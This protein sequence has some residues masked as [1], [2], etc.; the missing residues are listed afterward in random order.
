MCAQL[1]AD[2]PT[3]KILIY[4]DDPQ[5]ALVDLPGEFLGL[6][7]MV[8]RLHAHAPAFA[9]LE[10]TLVNRN[11]NAH[12]DRRIDVVLDEA[13]NAGQPFDEIWF[14]GIHQANLDKFSVGAFRGGQNSE[15]SATE[16]TA[17]ERWM[18]T[19]DGFQGGGVLITGDHAN[20]APPGL[21]PT[22]DSPCGD[23]SAASNSLGLGRAIGRCVPR[24][25]ALRIWEGPPTREP[26]DSFSTIAS[27]V[28]L[29]RFPQ[30]L[31]LRNV[32]VDGDPD[33]SGQPHPLFFYKPDEFIRVFPDHAH[34]GAVIIPQELNPAVWPSGSKGQTRPQIVA[35]GTDKRRDQ[36]LNIVATYNGDLAGVGRIVAD[37]TWHHYMNINLRGF[38]HPAP[39]GSASD[40]IGQFYGNLAVW[41]APRSKRIQ[42]ARAMSWELARYT[43][44]LE[45]H[46]NPESIGAAARWLMEQAASPCEVHELLQVLSPAESAAFIETTEQRIEST[47]DQQLFLGCVL[48]TYHEAMVRAESQSAAEAAANEAA[49][50]TVESL[51]DIALRK[52]VAEQEK[53]LRSKLEALSSANVN[54]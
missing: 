12:A 28:Q 33:D 7:S 1:S 40:Q 10:T 52:T 51:I 25:G 11:S 19:R 30:Q 45:R 47:A 44:L 48:E 8:Q 23:T 54:N 13:R 4:T 5:V 15:L 35:L 9:K 49:P 36:P 2:K 18:S 6:G 21:V 50:I 34:E 39:D 41:L 31:I 43:L 24:G 46:E 37:S 20:P 22:P 14:F 29:D 3:L 53:R 42:M 27:G 38:P 16:V 26:N 17:L 32:N